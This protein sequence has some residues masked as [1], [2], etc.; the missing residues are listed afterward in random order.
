MKTYTGRREGR[1]VLVRVNDQPLNPRLDLRNHSPT[2]YEWGYG[3]SGPAQLALALLV[4]HLG[5][6]EQALDFY[7]SFKWAVVARLPRWTEWS[8]TSRDIDQAIAGLP[9]PIG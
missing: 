8:L 4:D 5:D 7:Q 2:G 3:G 9:Q 6:I 1:A